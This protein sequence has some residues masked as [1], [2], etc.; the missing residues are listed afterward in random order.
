MS[1]HEGDQAI[2]GG[3]VPV[4]LSY[5]TAAAEFGEYRTEWS[6]PADYSAWDWYFLSTAPE[7]LSMKF[8]VYCQPG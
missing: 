4:G 3:D 8:V 6:G 7:L 2:G 5:N 1:C